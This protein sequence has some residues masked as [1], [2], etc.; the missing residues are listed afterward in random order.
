[1]QMPMQMPMP[2]PTPRPDLL[3]GSQHSVR[4]LAFRELSGVVLHSLVLDDTRTRAQVPWSFRCRCRGE[5]FTGSSRIWQVRCIAVMTS[6]WQPIAWCRF[7]PESG[8]KPSRTPSTWLQK[9]EKKPRLSGSSPKRSHQLPQ[10]HLAAS[11]SFCF[12]STD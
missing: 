5:R 3:L 4:A 8:A 12:A 2:M 9:R 7:W 11:F 10:M 1:M 6:G